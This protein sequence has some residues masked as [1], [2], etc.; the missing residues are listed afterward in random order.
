MCMMGTAFEYFEFQLFG[1]FTP[2]LVT[3]FLN[4]ALL[5]HQKYL[6]GYLLFS[7]AFIARLA[8]ACT[9]G[10][11][12]DHQSRNRAL[13]LA[14]W[15]MVVST[16]S[17]GILPDYQNL[18]LLGFYLLILLRLFQG[19]SLGGEFSMGSILLYET[20]S[21]PKCGKIWEAAWG[22]SWRPALL[23][24]LTNTFHWLFCNLMHGACHFLLHF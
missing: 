20:H 8:G 3:V 19:F 23:V 22:C 16:A 12:A 2:V 14:L 10:Y 17:I 11:I 1:L 6:I 13:L 5:E 21:A 4:P 18:G 7:L 9:L 24:F 15:I